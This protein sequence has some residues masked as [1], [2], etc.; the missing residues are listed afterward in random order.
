[1]RF[2]ERQSH[3]VVL[4]HEG[5]DTQEI[6]AK[7]LGNSLPLELQY[8]IVRSVHGLEQAEI[9]RPAYAIEY[10]FV[11]PTQLKPTLETKLIKGLYLAGQI[12]GTSGYE[13]AAAQGLWAGINAARAMQGERP[14]I[15][16][17]SEAYMAVLIDD[18][19][20]R[21]VDEPYRMF[22][23][24]AEYRLILRED[25]ATIR[26][27]GK[28]TELGLIGSEHLLSLQDKMRQI[29]Q[30]IEKLKA[31]PVKPSPEVNEHLSKLQSPPINNSTTLYGLLK[32]YEISYDDLA[33]FPG[34]QDQKDSFVKKQIEI[35]IKYEGYIKRQ[36][37]SVQKLKDQE[38]KKI[39]TNFDYSAVPGL[40]NELK[41]KL[42]KVAPQTL[43]QMERIPGMTEGAISAV[44]I[45]MKKQEAGNYP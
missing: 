8:Q 1:M 22:T 25:N 32:R 28:G 13:E 33:G 35:E 6:Y 19:V 20:T 2:H 5:L 3:P 38:K 43:G 36:F 23:S 42:T 11:Q 4:E 27:M 34:W 30:G 31:T 15:L 40:S 7:G 26:L 21:G 17:R 24:R 45:M 14:F 10:D 9:M 29:K 44:L 18:L 37:D 39:P 41:A 12:N 16:D